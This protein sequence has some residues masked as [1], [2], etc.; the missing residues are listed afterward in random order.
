METIEELTEIYLISRNSKTFERDFLN[1]LT[2][3]CISCILYFPKFEAVKV[4]FQKFL[5]C[6]GSYFRKVE[7]VR[8][9]FHFQRGFK[10]PRLAK[11]FVD[12]FSNFRGGI[13]YSDAYCF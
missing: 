9:H 6:F 11:I 3:K 13:C 10:F 5:K 4:S 1:C 12:V 2:D 7:I 8:K